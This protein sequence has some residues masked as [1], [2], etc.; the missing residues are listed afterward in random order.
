MPTSKTACV[1]SA[2]DVVLEAENKSTIKAEVLAVSAAVGGGVFVGAGL[3]I[4]APSPQNSI[5]YR[6]TGTYAP[7]EVQAYLKNSSVDAGARPEADR[8]LEQ[9][10]DAIVARRL[11]GRLGRRLRRHRR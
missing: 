2:R 5:G 3:S 4:G 6:P 7:I 1:E 10:I 9:N 8:D 11:G